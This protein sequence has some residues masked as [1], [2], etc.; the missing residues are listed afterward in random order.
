MD[1]I[2]TSTS[3]MYV[4]EDGILRVKVFA[5]AI[6]TLEKIK[7]NYA[8]YKELLGD[9]KVLLLID[10][11][12]KYTFTQEAR[13]Y[14]AGN[15]VKLNRIATA[16]V[17]GSIGGWLLA[18]VYIRLNRPVIPTRMFF[19]EVNALKWLRSFYIFPGDAYE[20]KKKRI[21]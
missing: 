12:E 16:F 1:K 3:E 9:K 10:S 18:S 15:E 13:A 6:V 2:R 8:V 11:R 5:N 7:E 14:A 19:R 17:V 4:D 20:S 21:S